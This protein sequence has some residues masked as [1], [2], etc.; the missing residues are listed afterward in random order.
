MS[1]AGHGIGLE[2]NELLILS[3]KDGSFLKKGCILAPDMHMLDR[4][5]K[6]EKLEDTVLVTGHGAEILNLSPREISEV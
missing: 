6:A 3:A 1:F 2:C 4:K 5:A